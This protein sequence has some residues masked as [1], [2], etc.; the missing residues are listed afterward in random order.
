[1]VQ[2]TKSRSEKIHLKT[3]VKSVGYSMPVE[4]A[5]YDLPLCGCSN[6]RGRASARMTDREDSVT[7]AHCLR[8]MR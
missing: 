6:Q 8:M 4:V 2:K 1:M 7:C 3:R 5:F